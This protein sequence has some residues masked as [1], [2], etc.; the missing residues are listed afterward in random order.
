MEKLGLSPKKPK[1]EE[2]TAEK[3][4]ELDNAKALQALIRAD[5][6][7]IITIL[8][9]EYGIEGLAFG[10]TVRRDPQSREQ[11][12][13]AQDIDFRVVAEDAKT[14][15]RAAKACRKKLEENGV[16]NISY[17][18]ATAY[19]NCPR[20][21]YTVRVGRNEIPVEIFFENR[22]DKTGMFG[23]LETEKIRHRR[24][25]GLD[26]ISRAQ[27]IRSLLVSLLSE[28]EHGE[29][30]RLQ[31]M[32]DLRKLYSKY[33]GRALERARERGDLDEWLSAGNPQLTELVEKNR[34]TLDGILFELR[35]TTNHANDNEPP[36]TAEAA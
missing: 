8:R 34:D 32:D 26:Q 23:G 29:G 33:T 14:A 13:A 7:A 17:E 24:V 5:L 10:S 21:A 25:E 9:E 18:V 16:V 30:K 2:T 15:E 6:D 4:P 27:D 36:E 3:L 22:Q 28:S 12:R 1:G 11:L 31:R 35:T 19:G 20:L